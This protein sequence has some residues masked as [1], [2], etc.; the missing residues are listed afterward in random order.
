MA[1]AREF[2][3]LSTALRR[4]NDEFRVRIKSPPLFALYLLD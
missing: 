3:A 4:S 2:E 1:E